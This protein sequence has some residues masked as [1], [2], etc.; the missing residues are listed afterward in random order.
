MSTLTGYRAIRAVIVRR[1]RA[2]VIVRAAYVVRA[3]AI[4]RTRIA[5]L[6]APVD[7]CLT[8]CTVVAGARAVAHRRC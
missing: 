6:R 3:S 5:V 4:V 1:T 2:H 8:L 7:R